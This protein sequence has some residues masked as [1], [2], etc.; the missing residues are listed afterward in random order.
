MTTCGKPLAPSGCR[1][2]LPEAQRAAGMGQAFAH[3]VCPQLAGSAG[4]GGS[5]T[6]DSGFGPVLTRSCLSRAAAIGK[7]IPHSTRET[8][9]S[10]SPPFLD[11]ERHGHVLGRHDLPRPAASKL[12][13]RCRRSGPNA[14]VSRPRPAALGDRS[15]AEETRVGV[16][17]VIRYEIAWTLLR[18]GHGPRLIQNPAVQYPNKIIGQNPLHDGRVVRGDAFGPC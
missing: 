1:L 10:A 18:S 16:I 7:S 14:R 12:R 5:M 17:Q 2:V 6:E 4:C 3:H 15:V 8:D 9:K 13:C 11:R